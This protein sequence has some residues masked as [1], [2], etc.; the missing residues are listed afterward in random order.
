[1]LLF[2]TAKALNRYRLRVSHTKQDLLQ[3]QA[4]QA[5]RMQKRRSKSR[6]ICIS[7]S[8][9]VRKL[10]MLTAKDD[11]VLSAGGCKHS[12]APYVLLTVLQA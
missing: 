11:D 4:L 12:E 3:A 2:W 8:S 6:V 10:Y 1:M 5:R 9:A 7:E